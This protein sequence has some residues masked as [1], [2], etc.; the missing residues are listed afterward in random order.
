MN[1]RLIK[2]LTVVV[3]L[4]TV[5][6]C[7]SKT[8]EG[9]IQERCSKDCVDAQSLLNA[10]RMV[11]DSLQLNYLIILSIIRVESNFSKKARNGSSVGLMQVHLRYHK[12]KFAKGDPFNPYS[13]IFV[14]GS[15]LKDCMNKVKNNSIK[16]YRCYNG[17][18]NSKYSSEVLKAYNEIK[19][20]QIS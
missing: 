18:G 19:Q 11:A 14:G 7:Y 3:M 2:I 16:A 10:S 6:V 13:N 15:I 17:G 9:Y 4:F 1:N 8:L 5:N 12:N 20:L